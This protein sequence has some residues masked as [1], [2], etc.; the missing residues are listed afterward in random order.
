MKNYF[1]GVAVGLGVL[2]LLPLT[3]PAQ[4]GPDFTD[5][6]EI[7]P[8]G[9]RGNTHVEGEVKYDESTQEY[10]IAG[11]GWDIQETGDEC[12]YAYRK[13]SGSF[14]IEAE[15]EWINGPHEWSK[16]GLMCR[17]STDAN[18][19]QTNIITSGH[20]TSPDRYEHG[21]RLTTGAGYTT[22][23]SNLP[24]E[25]WGLPTRLAI[26]R[27]APSNIFIRQFYN[28]VTEQWV[29]LP[30]TIEA[31]PEEILVGIAATS[32]IDDEASWAEA[33]FRNVTI[34]AVTGALATRTLPSVIY[35]PGEAAE[36]EI[37]IQGEAGDLTL[38]E[39]PPAGWTV[40]DISDGGTESGG[41]ITWSL[42]FE[43]GEKTVSYKVTPPATASDAGD[44]AGSLGSI[45]TAGMNSMVL[46]KPIG[47]FDNHMDIGAV[48]GEGDATLNSDTGEYQVIGSGADIWGGADEFH[49]A[50]SE[51]NGAFRLR[52][53]V[54]VEGIDSSDG[55]MKAAL[56]CRD[57]LA[58]DAVHY[59][60]LVRGSDLGVDAQ[61][62]T[63]PGAG[64]GSTSANMLTT[65]SQFGQL[66]IVRMGD[67]VS[68]Y[69]FDINTEEWT[70]Y[71]T[72]TI[73]FTDPVYAGLAVTS[74][75][76]G[77]WSVGYYTG[78]EL[79]IFPFGASR[80]VSADSVA[81]G[82]S[83]DVTVALDVSE[84]ETT[85]FTI[86]EQYPEGTS[87]SNVNAT[88]GEADDDGSGTITWT[89]SGVSEDGTLTYR[90]NIPSDMGGTVAL[91]GTYDDG[92]GYSGDLGQSELLLMAFPAAD[93]SP[94]DWHEDIGSVAAEGSVGRG[95]E[96]WAVV[97]SGADIWGTADAFHYL[98]K[99]V[100]GDF[101]MS[102]ENAAIIPFGET[103]TGN[104]WAKMGI[105]ARDSLDA[106]SAYT[107][108]MVRMEDQAYMFQ[109][110]EEAGIDAA[111]GFVADAAV[112]PP[113]HDGGFILERRDDDF[114]AFF[115]DA[116][117]GDEV[118]WDGWTVFM[119]DPI[120]VGI[121]V[122]SHEDGSLG[123]GM[124]SNV[125]FEGTSVPVET[126][127]LH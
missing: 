68:T 83:V 4:I 36:V 16:A 38:T 103:P 45:A 107:Y 76:D 100:E 9:T 112:Y 24:E 57:S 46:A 67:T 122:T 93:L 47:I 124:F 101:K 17:E 69:Y 109:Y 39:T 127:M 29:S 102:I 120:Y 1:V 7:I 92:A 95:G 96:D 21:A 27:I 8:T 12:F 49:F 5:T 119:E 32:H 88:V 110:R 3:V 91:S 70:L 108:A 11:N 42:A 81:P 26:I 14:R 50:Y 60:T 53:T 111:P 56:M 117:T 71:D 30:Q 104:N 66:E 52:A 82:G 2:L 15:L 94:F 19:V 62:R 10:Y 20:P 28:I 23:W 58:A 72:R 64:S 74:H 98:Y 51:I 121:A 13:I 18:S 75:S 89:G 78:V 33:T 97:G 116:N 106:G 84:G 48:G 35:R 43:G 73:N 40:S 25:M 6:A 87:V 113:D 55:W 90:L 99:R 41:T 118:E 34:E 59:D 31:M 80:S 65:D 85:D 22:G 105:M 77:Q 126:W 125:V 115:T 114:F 86:V 123:A 44:F 63:S 79:E 61:W 37:L 54:Y